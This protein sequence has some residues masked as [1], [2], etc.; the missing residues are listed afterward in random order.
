VLKSA[1]DSIAPHVEVAWITAMVLILPASAASVSS[2]IYT[3]S[4]TSAASSASATS[5]AALA[6]SLRVLASSFS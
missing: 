4:A 5:S 3:T 2:A 6:F 1:V